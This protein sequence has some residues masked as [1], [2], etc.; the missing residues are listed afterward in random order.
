M[1]KFK[2]R[3]NSGSTKLLISPMRHCKRTSAF[4]NYEKNQLK[5]KVGTCFVQD[6]LQRTNILNKRKSDKR[7]KKDK[8]KKTRKNKK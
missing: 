6:V 1:T 3:S 8:K 7:R 4:N 5:E 2:A